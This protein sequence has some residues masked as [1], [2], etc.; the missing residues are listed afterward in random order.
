MV[1]SPCNK[2]KSKSMKSIRKYGMGIKRIIALNILLFS[3]LISYAGF[4]DKAKNAL[5]KEFN[6]LEGIWIM[7][8]LIG[9]GLGIYV[10]MNKVQKVFLSNKAIVGRIPDYNLNAS[11][12][13]CI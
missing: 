13:P 12:W 6:S 4:A 2:E 8:G 1:V 7:L 5:S 9:G 3:S 10:I 11:A